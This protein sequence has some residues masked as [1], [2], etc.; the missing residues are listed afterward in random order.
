MFNDP[1]RLDDQGNAASDSK[2]ELGDHQP[3]RPSKTETVIAFIFQLV[4]AA[5]SISAVAIVIDIAFK[6]PES[7]TQSTPHKPVDPA[8]PL[9]QTPAEP[10][11]PIAD[12]GNN[13]PVDEGTANR[14]EH[15]TGTTSGPP[16]PI[17]RPRPPE[18]DIRYFVRITFSVADTFAPPKIERRPC[19]AEIDWPKVCDLPDAQRAVTPEILVEQPKG[20]APIAED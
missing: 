20:L 2:P 6:T 15:A 13:K 18:A 9:A 16:V 10:L 17:P 4:V 1:S 19:I 11:P 3:R 5:T 12:A 8:R 7:Q 14:T